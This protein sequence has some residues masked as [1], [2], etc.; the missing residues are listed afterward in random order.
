MDVTKE[1]DQ[2][3]FGVLFNFSE[4]T[5]VAKSIRS[6]FNKAGI[7]VKKYDSFLT[8]KFN[9]TNGKWVDNEYNHK[10]TRELI[11]NSSSMPAPFKTFYQRIGEFIGEIESKP[12]GFNDLFVVY[13][14]L[15]K[16][17]NK[18]LGELE[19]DACKKAIQDYMVIWHQCDEKAQKDFPISRL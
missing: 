14:F 6:N 17:L 16:N 4:P 9:L 10:L 18:D 13:T 7:E 8:V 1:F 5:L 15:L 11:S 12:G 2:A 3:F 19:K